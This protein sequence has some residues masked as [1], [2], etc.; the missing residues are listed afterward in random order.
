[1]RPL[2]PR[3]AAR[4][5]IRFAA[6]LAA[7]LALAG[8][9]PGTADEA[10]APG[11]TF[12]AI[13]TRILAPTCAVG[14][15]HA[16]NPGAGGLSLAASGAYDALVGARP[17]NTAARE[18]GYLLVRPSDPDRSFL[19]HKVERPD[20][21]AHLDEGHGALMPLGGAP[22]TDGQVAFIRAWIEAG[23]PANG[24]VADTALLRPAPPVEAVPFVPP[25]PPASGVQ[26]HLGP[27]ETA[28]RT[29]REVFAYQRL[30]TPDTLF[31]R[32]FEAKMRPGT[33]H[34]I[35]YSQSAN[36]PEGVLRDFRG[37]STFDE[38]I[39]FNTRGF[40]FGAQAPE[41]TVDFPAGVVLP[42]PPNTGFDLNSHY[43]NAGATP[44]TGEV[45]LNLHTVARTA[46]LKIAKP[47][48]D[49]FT[50]FVLPAGRRTVVERTVTFPD[51]RRVLMF[52]AHT[53]RLNESFKI[54]G[55][56]GAHD[57]KLLYESFQWDHPAISYFSTPLAFPPRTGYRIVA[58]YNNTTAREVRFGFT[59]ADEM[60]IALGYY[61]R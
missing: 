18:A 12:H 45:Y 5:A 35:L 51:A 49:G 54:Y 47:I 43:A 21:H 34:F 19:L 24:V 1:M 6:P 17:S 38:M 10:P 8:C 28:G 22:L 61:Y 23:A 11:G 7:L 32:A 46:G 20:G 55:V 56:G 36:L 58:T 53:H 9:D 57:G 44:M 13:Q 42:I 27:F 16:G 52:S 15:C 40:V 41:V 50:D 60:C 59:S 48:F 3:P 29:E 2:A 37:T 4:R 31:V 33:H 25:A 26:M 30:R 14:G 39:H